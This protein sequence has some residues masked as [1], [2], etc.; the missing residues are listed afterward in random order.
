MRR[1]LALLVGLALALAACDAAPVLPRSEALLVTVEGEGG[2]CPQGICQWRMD[3]FGDG[4]VRQAD[5]TQRQ[6]DP[7]ATARVAA[8]IAAADWDAILARPFS[9][10]CPTAFDGQELTY[11]F[12]VAGEPV[13]VASCSVQ[14][15]PGQEPFA[16]IDAVLFAAGG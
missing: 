9:G 8:A 10:E 6:A 7:D 2:E 3:L 16:S 13:V 11:T 12:P 1:H 4:R 15:D 14:I 5:G